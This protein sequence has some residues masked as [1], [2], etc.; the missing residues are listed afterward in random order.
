MNGITD[1]LLNEIK[2][3]DFNNGDL[4][5]IKD[6]VG[7]D[8]A[9]QLFEKIPG[10][11]VYIPQGTNFKEPYLRILNQPEYQDL[12]NKELALKLAVSPTFISDCRLLNKIANAKK[13]Q[14][15]L[16]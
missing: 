4:K 6:N 3:E 12:S 10:I 2:P 9:K 14:A 11:S 15:R 8:V 1:I 5:L 13:N 16:F 7:F